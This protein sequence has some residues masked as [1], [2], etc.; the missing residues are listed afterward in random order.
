M[1]EL[2]GG[3]GKA[4]G[5]GWEGQGGGNRFSRAASSSS[6]SPC[7]NCAGKYCAGNDFYN[8]IKL[9]LAMICSSM[10]VQPGGRRK[11]GGLREMG[12]REVRW[13]RLDMDRH[14]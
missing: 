8:T 14:Q 12:E 5:R 4:G 7:I 10:V 3:E 1:R 13:G 6:S 11:G 2:R 9:S